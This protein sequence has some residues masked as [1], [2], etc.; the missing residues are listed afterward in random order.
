LQTI[1]GRKRVRQ[2]NPCLFRFPMTATGE[3]WL[4]IK[5][6]V[7]RTQEGGEEGRGTHNEMALSFSKCLK[8][9]WCLTLLNPKV[10]LNSFS[11]C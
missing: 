4:P 6:N 7:M 11:S 10:L 3:K 9:M 1:Y 8:T 5:V 2:K